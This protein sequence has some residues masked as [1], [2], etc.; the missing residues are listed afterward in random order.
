MVFAVDLCSPRRATRRGRCR[1]H[2]F[3]TLELFAF[4]SQTPLHLG[5]G[6]AWRRTGASGLRLHGFVLNISRDDATGPTGGRTLVATDSMPSS[7]KRSCGPCEGSAPE[8]SSSPAETWKTPSAATCIS[9]RGASPASVLL[10]AEATPTTLSSSKPAR[11]DH[12]CPVGQQAIQ[13]SRQRPHVIFLHPQQVLLAATVVGPEDD[14]LNR[15][16]V[17]VGDVEETRAVS[18]SFFCPR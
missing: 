13:G 11:P 14:L 9:P 2:W 4:S 5:C 17:L 15:L 12:V 10:P 3:V 6:L 18:R 1:R 7:G 8:Y 16:F